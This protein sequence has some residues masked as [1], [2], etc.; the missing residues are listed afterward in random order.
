MRTR[1]DLKGIQ[2]H[3]CHFML[4]PGAILWFKA[5]GGSVYWTHNVTV[6]AKLMG[7]VFI[8]EG[9]AFAG[10]HSENSRRNHPRSMSVADKATYRPGGFF[11]AL[12]LSDMNGGCVV[13]QVEG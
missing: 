4:Q 11:A 2:A 7:S 10:V 5:H 8:S 12:F 3:W 13:L 1:A 9:A 6:P